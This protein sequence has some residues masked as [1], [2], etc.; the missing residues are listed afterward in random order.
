MSK[1]DVLAVNHSEIP[2]SSFGLYLKELAAEIVSNG[3]P[4]GDLLEEMQA[5]HAR[6]R[7]FAMEMAEGRTD[8]AKKV[9]EAIC[10][11][12]YCTATIRRMFDRMQER[13]DDVVRTRLISEGHAAMARVSEAR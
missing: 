10:T 13:E 12:V 5:A 3:D 11:A 9:R 4:S 6:R 8:R 1:V 7:R 2:N